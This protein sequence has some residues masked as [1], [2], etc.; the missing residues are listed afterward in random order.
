MRARAAILALFVATLVAPALSV[1]LLTHRDV[2]LRWNFAVVAFVETSVLLVGVLLARRRLGLTLSALLLG[3][4]DFGV[5][6]AVVEPDSIVAGVITGALLAPLVVLLSLPAVV[7]CA[8][9]LERPALDGPHAVAFVSGTWLGVLFALVSI[10]ARDP[11]ACIVACGDLGIAS[12]A[13]GL[14]SRRARAIEAI[15]HGSNKTLE[16]VAD[17]DAGHT[18]PWLAP[19]RDGS[20]FEVVVRRNEASYRHDPTDALVRFEPFVLHSTLA[21]FVGAYVRRAPFR[22]REIWLLVFTTMVAIA[23]GAGMATWRSY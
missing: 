13:Y 12:I 21:R 14:S 6:I 1:F 2:W 11:L 18:A 22:S 5:F 8:T 23:I 9:A 15:R 10:F 19:P 3:A 4:I 7:T 16:I 17:H 20:T